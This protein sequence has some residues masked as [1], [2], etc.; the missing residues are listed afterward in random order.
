MS[1]SPKNSSR[2]RRNITAIDP[3]T[4]VESDLK[5]EYDR[6]LAKRDW[7]EEIQKEL[8]DLDT[9]ENGC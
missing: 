2:V 7:Q 6:T 1:K 5:T 8:E 4:K 9:D 3:T